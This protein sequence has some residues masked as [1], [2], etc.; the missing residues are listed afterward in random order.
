MKN[1]VHYIVFISF[2][3]S[4][5]AIGD[6]DPHFEVKGYTLIQDSWVFS[7]DKAK[8]VRDRLIDLDVSLKTNESLQKSIDLYKLN[9][10]IQQKQLDIVLQQNDKLAS[11]LQSERTLNNWERFGCFLL[12]IAATVGAGWAISRVK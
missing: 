8:S 9:E 4:Q 3:I 12:G 7:Q 2:F 5:I 6:T 11:A 1:I 10:T